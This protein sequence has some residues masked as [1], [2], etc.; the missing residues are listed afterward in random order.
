VIKISEFADK[1]YLVTGASTGIGAAVA[2]ALARQGARIA[3]HYRRSDAE[4]EKVLAEIAAAGGE[5]YAIKGDIAARGGADTAVRLTV[6]RFGQLDGLVNNAGALLERRALS[7]WD[8]AFVDTMLDLNLRAL[9]TGCRAALP[10]LRKTRGAIVN[11]SSIAARTGGGPGAALYAASKGFVSTLT[12]GL[13]RE[14]VADGIRVNAVS[15]G[16]IDTPLHARYSTAEQLEAM[17]KSIPMGRLGA[18]EDCVGAFL[19]LLSGELSGYV[20]GQI[21]EVNGGQ[22]MP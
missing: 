14:L 21:I 1:V 4:A 9:V 22:A 3:I 15:P 11:T 5:G 13:A 16:V 2:T 12:R 19:W 17:R 18:P 20:T 10:H 7:D 8:D 6:E